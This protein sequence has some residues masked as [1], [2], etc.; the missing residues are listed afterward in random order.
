MYK[1]KADFILSEDNILLVGQK[2][3]LRVFCH[4]VV[5]CSK[6]NK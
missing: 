1:L 5:V 3:E 6:R 2:T 4:I